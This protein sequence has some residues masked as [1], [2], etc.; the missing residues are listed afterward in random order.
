VSYLLLVQ[1]LISQDTSFTVP[2]LVLLLGLAGALAE[3]RWRVGQAERHLDKSEERVQRL[4]ARLAAVE[5][6]QASHGVVLG[7]LK[8]LLTEVR[9]ELRNNRAA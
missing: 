9:D 6:Q 5:V 4:E 8:A 3:A 7:E 1:T 2:I